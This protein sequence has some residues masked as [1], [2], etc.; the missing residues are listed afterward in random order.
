VRDLVTSYQGELNIGSSEVLGGASF[1]LC[2][3]NMG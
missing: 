2:F 3:N 1:T